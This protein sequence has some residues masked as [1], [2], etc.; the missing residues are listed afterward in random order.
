MAVITIAVCDEVRKDAQKLVKKLSEL[1]PEAEIL[2][3]RNRE[4]LLNGLKDEHKRCDV[5]FMG[6]DGEKGENLETVRAIRLGGNY[7]PVVLVAAN[8]H[9]Y[10]E[11]FE[12]FAF[13]SI[14]KPVGIGELE[15][16]MKPILRSCELD[17][18]KA[19]HFQYRTQIYTL[20][21]RRLVYISSSLHNVVFHLTDGTV[22]RCRARLADFSDQLT[23]SSFLRCHQSFL[24]NLDKVTSLNKSSFMVGGTEIPIS[25]NYLKNSRQKYKDYLEQQKVSS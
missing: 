16:V 18:G 12:V 9:F 17:G 2:V 19:L 21:H 8:D 15:H 6:L 20:Q 7:V 24:I 22:I 13:N 25:R 10:K 23:D 11:A 1:I 5:L 14:T 4:S 3:Y